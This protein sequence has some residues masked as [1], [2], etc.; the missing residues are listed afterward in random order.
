MADPVDILDLAARRLHRARSAFVGAMHMQ[1]SESATVNIMA[2]RV[3]LSLAS[4]DME[5][6]RAVALELAAA[7]G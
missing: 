6:A 5:N 1:D 7:A 2:A 3:S 4:E